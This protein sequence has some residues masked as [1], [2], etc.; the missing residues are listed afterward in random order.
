VTSTEQTNGDSA[1]VPPRLTPLPEELWDARTRGLLKAVARDPGGHVPNIFATLVRHPDLYERFLPFG[2]YLLRG[3]VLTGRTRELLI[4]RTA[5]NT[6]AAYERGRHVPLAMAAG[7]TEAEITRA[8]L[9]PEADGWDGRDRLLL[10]AADELHLDAR[11][12]AGTWQALAA[13]HDEQELIEIT[14]LVGQYH[15]VA[16]FLNSAGTP[17][18]PGFTPPTPAQHA[19]RGEDPSHE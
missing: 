5:H 8:P 3:G 9:G 6:R 11:L 19:P 7:L 1:E 16:F 12:S 14:L 18:D 2:G 4:L 13:D 17:L 15:M 10:R